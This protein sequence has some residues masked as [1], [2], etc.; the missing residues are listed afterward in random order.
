MKTSSL[1]AT[2]LFIYSSAFGQNESCPSTTPCTPCCNPCVPQECIQLTPGYNAPIQRCCEQ[3]S[4]D[5]FITGGFIYWNPK[6]ENMELG[7]VSQ[8]DAPIYIVDGHVTNLEAEYSPGFQIGMGLNLNRDNWD[9]YLRYTWLRSHDSATTNLDPTKNAQLSPFWQ[10][11]LTQGGS[12]PAYYFGHEKWKLHMD[13]L[14]LELGRTYY[15]GKHLVLRPFF[16][17]RGA[18]IRQRIDVDYLNAASGLNPANVYIRQ[19]FNSWGVGP[20]TGFSSRWLI[21]KNFRLYGD[22]AADILFTQYRRLGCNQFGTNA[23]GTLTSQSGFHVN[24]RN[25]NHL[26]GHFEL[27]F[28][29]GWQTECCMNRRWIIDLSAGYNYQIFFSQN[30]FRHY[31]NNFSFVSLMPAGD[32][33]VHGLTATAR[34][35]F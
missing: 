31:L 17:A 1:I 24:Q 28:G 32:L 27:E 3:N 13:L 11:P 33:H 25:S 14:D 30:M 7:I 19:L 16:G 12:N 34:V 5:L 15:V 6:Q 9:T 21:G 4:W 26:R 10:I 22:G 20:R 18:W 29:F 23:F 2:S 8:P 35:D